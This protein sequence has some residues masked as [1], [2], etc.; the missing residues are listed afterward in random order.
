MFPH[1]LEV[2]TLL[3]DIKIKKVFRADKFA[4]KISWK[5]PSVYDRMM[6][7]FE[8]SYIERSAYEQAKY[9]NRFWRTV[10][11]TQCFLRFHADCGKG[12]ESGQ[13]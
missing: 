8:I 4:I 13:I 3:A 2:L 6:I 12:S 10:I 11:R 7:N 5:N 1:S 9:C